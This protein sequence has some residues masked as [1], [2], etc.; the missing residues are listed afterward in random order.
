MVKAT[1]IDN[2]V[3][4]EEPYLHQDWSLMLASMKQGIAGIEGECGV[5]LAVIIVQFSE[6]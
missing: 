3:V 4:E 5:S 2:R 1:Y 6:T